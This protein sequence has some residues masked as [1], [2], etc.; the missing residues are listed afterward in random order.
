MK[1]MPCVIIESP[2]SGDLETHKEYLCRCMIDSLQRGEAPFASHMLYTQVLDDG[3]F[4]E[5]R[6]GIQ[7][8]YAWSNI[9]DRIIFYL[10]YGW[11]GGMV[12]A[13]N[14]CKNY[15][16]CVLEFRNIGINPV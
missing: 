12:K 4:A 6:L 9:A 10:D 8:G 7:C 15:K 16:D 2:Y 1:K 13:L 11:S 3:I 14:N 5:R